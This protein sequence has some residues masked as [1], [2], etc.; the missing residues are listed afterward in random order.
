MGSVPLGNPDL[1]TPHTWGPQ[2]T[3]LCPQSLTEPGREVPGSQNRWGGVENRGREDS[4]WGQ[5]GTDGTKEARMRVST[6][7]PSFWANLQGLRSHSSLCECSHIIPW[8]AVHTDDTVNMPLELCHV[9]A[10]QA[11]VD[12]DSLQAIR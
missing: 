5:M 4:V 2:L 9:L 7:N 11:P 3:H 8:S 12:K 1:H 10:L 6:A